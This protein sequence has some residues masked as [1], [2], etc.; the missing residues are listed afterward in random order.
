MKI[1]LFRHGETDWNTE[2]RIQGHSD[3][4]LNANGIRQAETVAKKIADLRFDA[5]FSSPLKRAAKTAQIMTEALSNPAP[6]I[7]YDERLYEIGFGVEEGDD[8]EHIVEDETDPL[9]NY[10]MAPEKYIPPEGAESID[11]VWKRFQDFFEERVLPLEEESGERE[12]NV[13]IIAHGAL[14]R[15]V[16]CNLSGRLYKHFWGKKR[17]TNLALNLLELKDGRLTLIEEARD[18]LPPGELMPEHKLYAEAVKRN[19]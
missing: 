7:I 11:D 16:T 2:N 15:T 18:M 19:M 14:A 17:M 9:H 12:K 6:P 13:L 10:I 8:L 1:Y 5:V 3:I 4:P